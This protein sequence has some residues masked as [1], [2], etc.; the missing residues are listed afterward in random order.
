MAH[1]RAGNHER[2]V[3]HLRTALA[4]WSNFE[5]RAMCYPL[6]AMAYHRLGRA[7]EAQGAL[8]ETRRAVKG[9]ME[10]T[11]RSDDPQFV[12]ILWWDWLECRLFW[13][14]AEVLLGNPPPPEADYRLTFAR[15]RS[16]AVLGRKDESLAEFRRAI[17]EQ[18]DDV[19]VRLACFRICAAQRWWA[20][21]ETF[22]E[23]ARALRPTD[24]QVPFEAFKV[25]LKQDQWDRA[26]AERARAVALQPTHTALRLALFYHFH[27]QEDW[28]KADAECER[29]LKEVPDDV[30]VR[31]ALSG[32]YM[33][34]KQ[35]A[36][37]APIL[38]A[39]V[40]LQPG[41]AKAWNWKGNCAFRRGRWREAADANTEA[42]RLQPDYHLYLANRAT[43][44]LMLEEWD[45]AAADSAQAMR[46]DPENGNFY[47]DYALACL[48]RGKFEEY[49]KACTSM[50]QRANRTWS[51][52]LPGIT[53]WT[54]TLGPADPARA[55]D[56]AKW[57]EQ[58]RTTGGAEYADPIFVSYLGRALYRAGKLKEALDRL[59]ETRGLR[60]T[61]K[62]DDALD[63]LFLAMIQ[64][65]LGNAELARR[66]M[67]RA[68]EAY[69]LPP[70]TDPKP[71]AAPDGERENARHWLGF[72]FLYHEAEAMLKGRPGPG[73]GKD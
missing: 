19:Q 3:E 49:G 41:N 46:L 7:E 36:K 51:D 35:Y 63:C 50:R 38:D 2:A 72:C 39:C 8:E 65:R 9:W 64:H 6:L 58:A 17:K 27:S 14:E 33:D 54:C 30:D 45:L 69:G 23:Q 22:L 31:L 61:G 1:Y 18:P 26:I 37:A 16:L 47:R 11:L 55:Q 40:R 4:R 57:I 10:A 59:E 29:V 53:M 67:D 66:E 20:E 12:R 21:G 71:G 70:G 42:A 25:Y 15:G 48:H 60:P 28:A 73:E 62:K 44:R 56:T 43:P 24:A 32:A 13:R 52:S 5:D 68:R 34:K